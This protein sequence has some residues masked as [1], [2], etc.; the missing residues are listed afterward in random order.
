MATKDIITNNNDEKS[1]SKFD[2][3]FWLKLVSGFVIAFFIFFIILYFTELQAPSVFSTSPI[4]SID[5]GCGLNTLAEDLYKAKV[6]RSPFWFKSIAVIL[7]GTKGIIAGDYVLNKNE[8]IFNLTYRMTIGDYQLEKVKI[9]IPEGLNTYEIAKLVKVKFPKISEAQF[10]D[11]AKNLE[12]YLFPDTYIL[13]IN[14]TTDT[15][16]RAMQDNYQRKILE[17][18]DLIKSSDKTESDIMKMAS[19]LED[20]ART[21]ES[22]Q[23]VSGILWR[24][25]SIG[26]PLQVDATFKYINGKVTSTL[27]LTDLK[28]DSPY[29]TYVYKGLPPTPICNP[30]MDSIKAALTPTKTSYLYF[31]TD[32][33][34]DMHYSKTYAEHLHNKELY[35]E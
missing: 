27:S 26:M 22:R 20:E 12:G 11:K 21:T 34:G 4:Y 35:L 30:G 5:C 15:V 33:D 14:A 18:A 6:I 10:M 2:R 9:T 19:I 28:L 1:G 31:L 16:I 32:N 7:G 8:N 3:F 13:E 24:R 23:I 25:L 29:N 17:V